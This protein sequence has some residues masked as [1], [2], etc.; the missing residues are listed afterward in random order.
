MKKEQTVDKKPIKKRILKF[1]LITLILLIIILGV[2]FGIKTKKFQEIAQEM[3]QNENSQIVDKSGEEIAVIGSSRKRENVE[4]S[5]IPENLV[6]AYISIEDQRFYKHNG[7]DIKR[8]VSAI[9]SYIIHFGKSSFGGSSI[10]QQLVKNLTGDDS[11]SVSR[12]VSEWGRAI[13]LEM[14]LS[15]EEIL[16]AYLNIIYVGPNIYGVQ[17]GSNYYFSKDV[18]DLSLAEC[19]FLA[20]IN[21]SPNSYNPFG[22]KDNSEKIQKRTKTVLKKMLELKY[23]GEDEYKVAIEEVENG[24][25]FKNG[26]IESNGSNVYSSH[27]D[28]LITSL[29]NELKEEKNISEDFAENYLSMA[30]LK[31]YSTQDSNIQKILEEEF[32]KSKYVL[33]SANDSSVASQAAM[34]VINQENGQVVGLVGE[35]GKKTS[36]RG[37]NRAT[38]SKR[39][40]GSAFKPLAVL[41][42]SIQEK[43]ITA[44]SIIEDEETTFDDGT[45]AGYTPKD[46][47]GY[48]GKITVRRAVESS[49]NI[50][51][52]K[53]MEKLSTKKSIKYLKKMGITSLN[54]NDTSLALALGG[55]DKGITPL[56]MAAAYACIAN[57]GI[58]IE[59]IF[60]TKVVD[61][62]GK[63]VGKIKQKTR[64][65]FSKETA[66]I[67]KELLTEPVKGQNGTATYCNIDK[68]DV[69][70]KTGTTNEDYDRWLCGFTP[71]YTAVTW[72]G[73]DQNETINY[74]GKN[75]AGLL[76]SA[77]MKNIHKNL[78]NK[79]F[80]K[81]NGIVTMKICK[82]T[83]LC[84]NSSCKDTYTEFFLKGTTPD[85]CSKHS[86]SQS[87][88][89]ETK[90]TTTTTTKKQNESVKQENTNVQKNTTKIE[91]II[92]ENTNHEE[93]NI[94]VE[95]NT[96]NNEENIVEENNITEEIEKNEVTKKREDK[97]ETNSTE[98]NKIENN[99]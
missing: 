94:I 91:N 71:Y 14:C 69:A 70:A 78:E 77:C 64:K 54:E 80:D 44:A 45:E 39:Q 29:I 67:V 38:Q 17:A 76:W 72:Y 15:K 68:M 63:E 36:S 43:I 74:N 81:P 47:N 20:G 30:G 61:L 19:S 12:K 26:K 13:A 62:S 24:L 7:V 31:I 3:I 60:Y 46:Y 56:E 58:Y 88:K 97:Q 10:T 34:V 87:V 95:N 28:A 75:P 96:T 82:E 99:Y 18:K 4:F 53:M 40:T 33:K 93:E 65:V 85:I 25:N 2:K 23:I 52:V 98:N 1:I 79:S 21:N 48:L 55:L 11:N 37:L 50:P 84:A 83:G 35:L 51:F 49:Q 32:S 92:V 9:G 5:E 66:Y 42:P 8:T 90:N 6:N 27:T 57:D 73:F 86:A 16:N 22:E 89:N 59:P 41:A